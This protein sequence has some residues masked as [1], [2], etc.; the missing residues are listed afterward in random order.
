MI[1]HLI[2]KQF[3]DSLLNPKLHLQSFCAKH[4]KWTSQ[5]KGVRIDNTQLLKSCYSLGCVIFQEHPLPTF[6][7]FP[8]QKETL[9]ILQSSLH[10]F[11][12]KLL[13]NYL[14]SR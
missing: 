3:L 8:P 1:I 11:G 13:T 14:L 7:F 9:Y 6:F 12:E 2:T 5:K 10:R 4:Q